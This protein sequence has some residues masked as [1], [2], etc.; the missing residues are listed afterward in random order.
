MPFPSN[1]A[2]RSAP[3]R[4]GAAFLLGL[5]VVVAAR[6]A[7]AQRG[8]DYAPT[9]DLAVSPNPNQGSRGVVD[10]EVA[11]KGGWVANAPATILDYGLTSRL[12]VG[13]AVASF[14]TVLV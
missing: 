11:P 9:E 8:Q 7:A 2:D 3:A 1:T 12:T 13:I 4:Y 14:G 10:T 6:P 5:A